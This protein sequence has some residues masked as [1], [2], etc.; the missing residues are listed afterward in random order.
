MERRESGGDLGLRPEKEALSLHPSINAKVHLL[1][2]LSYGCDRS[3]KHLV[4]AKHTVY[5]NYLVTI[6][7]L[8]RISM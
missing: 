1:L 7:T 5:L 4:Y 8:M 3:P 6:V 2:N